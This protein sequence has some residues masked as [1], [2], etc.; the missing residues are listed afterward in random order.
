MHSITA[1]TA[2]TRRLTHSEN[3][4]KERSVALSR[5]AE[6]LFSFAQAEKDCITIAEY[7]IIL[8]VTYKIPVQG[9][10]DAKP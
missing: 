4:K 8:N 5:S 2:D 1:R 7:I 9:A 10:K 6:R 3:S